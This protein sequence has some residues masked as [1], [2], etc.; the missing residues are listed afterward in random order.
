MGVTLTRRLG[1]IVPAFALAVMLA[2]CAWAHPEPPARIVTAAAAYAQQLEGLTGVASATAEVEAVDPKDRPDEWF[3]RVSVEADSAELIATLPDAISGIRSPSGAETTFAVVFPSEDGIAPVTLS[4]LSGAS[5]E[6]AMLLSTIPAV[7]GVSVGAEGSSVILSADTTLVE[8]ATLLRDSGTL[9]MGP[10]TTVRVGYGTHKG[11]VDV[12]LD[13]P[14][15]PLLGLLQEL[16]DD[17]DVES[18]TAIEPSA[19]SPRPSVYVSSENASKAVDALAALTGDEVDGRPRTAFSVRGVGE[20]IRGFVGL[21]LG[22]PEPDDLASPVPQPVDMTVHLAEYTET[23]Q[24]FL[25]DTAIAAGIPGSPQ[26]YVTDCSGAE[27]VSQV[28]GM[29]VL[30]VFAYADTAVPTYDAVTAFWE[31]RGYTHSDQALGTASYSPVIAEQV[32]LATIR[33]TS[34]GIHIRVVSACAG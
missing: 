25:T 22:S 15:G 9:V 26:V 16:N 20:P 6:R 14:S 2:G 29:L 24:A 3:V 13:G 12:S 28:E 5:R 7:I 30:E 1:S 32:A 10:T 31:R 17:P 27:G 23:V 4:D 18:V 33:G 19:Q 8:A 34:D 11:F 21:E